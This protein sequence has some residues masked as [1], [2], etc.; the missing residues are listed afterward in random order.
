M[1]V[2]LR[3]MAIKKLMGEKRM[4]ATALAKLCGMS[5]QNMSTVLNRGTCSVTNA[6]LLADA[7]GVEFEEIVKED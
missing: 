2:K 1:I 4:T 3:V 6:Y 5:R 7:L